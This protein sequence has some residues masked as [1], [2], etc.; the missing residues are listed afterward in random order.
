MHLPF[1]KKL[2]SIASTTSENTPQLLNLEVFCFFFENFYL[3]GCEGTTFLSVQQLCLWELFINLYQSFVLRIEGMKYFPRGSKQ[4]KQSFWRWWCAEQHLEESVRWQ[5]QKF[6][7][8]FFF[9][10]EGCLAV[11]KPLPVAH[12]VSCL[13]GV[14]ST[15]F[16][17]L[18]RVSPPTWHMPRCCCHLPHRVGAVPFI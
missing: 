6:P 7:P 11:K 2:T 3:Q 1:S 10:M 8:L 18:A 9:M 16:P 12:V 5:A 13:L 14:F 4:T 15:A 17:S